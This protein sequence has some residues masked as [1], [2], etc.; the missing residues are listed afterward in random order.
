MIDLKPHSYL[1]ARLAP[2]W[3]TTGEPIWACVVKAGFEYD[4]QGRVQPLR[5]S[6]PVVESDEY[7]EDDPEHHAPTAVKETVPFKKGS[8]LLLYGHAR[9]DTPLPFWKISLS[10]ET[11]S[12]IHWEKSLAVF[13]PRHW[14]RGVLGMTPSEPDPITELPLQYNYAYGGRN[15][16]KEDDTYPENPVGIGYLGT[17]LRKQ[18]HEQPLPQ[19]VSA[20][21]KLAG[22]DKTQTPQGFGPIPSHWEPRA[23]LFPDIDETRLR[24]ENQSPYTE[25]LPDNL[26][27]TAPSD[28]QFDRPISGE[29]RLT[30][31]GMTSGLDVA[32]PITLVWTAPKVQLS[33]TRNGDTAIRPL[34]A[35]TLVVDTEQQRFHLL[36]RHTFPRHTMDPKTDITL[37][38]VE[39][40]HD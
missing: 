3:S 14:R 12:G 11:G 37:A 5:E 6:E 17:G 21:I 29:C 38:L 1:Q 8:E 26:Y 22:P 15:P 36:Y 4:A 40:E 18:A 24:Q 34:D 35:D 20:N 32:T 2:D 10:L 13:G 7:P 33:I 27:N 30:L 25:P 31:Q 23:G 16:H 28:Q 9:S 39:N 19:I